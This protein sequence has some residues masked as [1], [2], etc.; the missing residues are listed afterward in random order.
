MTETA[1]EKKAR[2]DLEVAEA[3]QGSLLKAREAE[4]KQLDAEAKK[5]A[6]DSKKDREREA[7]LAVKASEQDA[8]DIEA[9]LAAHRGERLLRGENG[10]LGHLDT[11]VGD[12]EER[13]RVEREEAVDGKKS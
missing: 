11:Q 9:F 3:Q 1:D 10:A 7:S 13:L 5:V 4:Q 12:R 2:E 6:A 8:K